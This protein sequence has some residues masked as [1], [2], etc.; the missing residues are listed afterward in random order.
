MVNGT[1]MSVCRDEILWVQREGWLWGT[2]VTVAIISL[3]ETLLLTYLGYK[4]LLYIA[5]YVNPLL[6]VT[7]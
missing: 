2:Q 6:T 7:L 1:C 3:G 4:V 5:C